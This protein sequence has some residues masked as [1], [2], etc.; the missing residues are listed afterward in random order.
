MPTADKFSSK[1]IVR[2]VWLQKFSRNILKF[3]HEN[4]F[5]PNNWSSLESSAVKY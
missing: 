2:K 4:G 3:L 5:Y 1:M